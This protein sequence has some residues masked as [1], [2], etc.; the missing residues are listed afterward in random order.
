MSSRNMLVKKRSG[1]WYRFKV[2]LLVILPLLVL[3][4]G[5]YAVFYSSLFSV[6]AIEVRGADIKADDILAGRRFTNILFTFPAIDPA[7][8]PEI[9]DFTVSKNYLARKVIVE[10]T[11]RERTLIWCLA[12]AGGCF[13]IDPSGFIF[14]DALEPSGGNIKAVHDSTGRGLGVGGYA[15]PADMFTNLTS[16]LNLLKESGVTISE[17]RIDNLNFQEFTVTTTG[18]AKL[19]FSLRYDPASQGGNVALKS[20][21]DAIGRGNVCVDMRI[22]PRVYTSKICSD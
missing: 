16:A 8:F 6:R 10:A 22:L 4:G 2:A 11:P 20:E 9:A 21:A 18:G 7:R 1:A 12:P 19:R 3:C 5:I 15:L 13:W 14:E 17:V